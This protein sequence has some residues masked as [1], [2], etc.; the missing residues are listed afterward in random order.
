MRRLIALGLLFAAVPAYAQDN[1]RLNAQ[2]HH[3]YE[4]HFIQEPYKVKVCRD[5]TT[6]GDKT[7]DTLGGAILGGILGKVLTG[8]DEG[9]K[10][11]A[12][13]GGVIGH[14]ESNAQ[15]GTHRVC[16][17]ETKYREKEQTFYSHSTITWRMNGREYRVR[18]QK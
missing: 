7:G 9:A 18:F 3:H 10:M 17:I 16:Q 14:N 6:S 1:V 15:A 8:S 2:I 12:L 13:F 11:G 4:R 5:K